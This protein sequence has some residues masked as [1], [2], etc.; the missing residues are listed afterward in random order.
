MN[1]LLSLVAATALAIGLTALVAPAHADPYPGTVA[2][3]T[4]ADPANRTPRHHKVHLR[5]AVAANGNVAP[6]GT[7]VIRVFRHGHHIRTYRRSYS[8][9][10]RVR[11]S[12]GRYN[13]AGH[14]SVRIR[15]LPTAGSVFAGSA[16]V[17]EGFHVTR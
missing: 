1:K 4:L 3:V 6:S 7:V 9:P 13:K 2:T 16:S 17:R 8:G 10:G 5:F 11:I 12:I 15:Y 14:Y